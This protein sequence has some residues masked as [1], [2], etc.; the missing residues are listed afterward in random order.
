MDGYHHIILSHKREG[1]VRMVTVQT[2]IRRI[3]RSRGISQCGF[4]PY[5]AVLP[6]LPVRSQSRIPS[7]A[8]TVI[9][10]LFPYYIGEYPHR[11]I[12]RYAVPDDYHLLAGGL[13]ESCAEALGKMFP[14]H[15][16]VPFVDS[17]PIREVQGAYLAGLGYR[18]KNGLLIHPKFGSYV[19]IGELVTTLEI[20]ADREPLGECLSCGR[21]LRACPAGALEDTGLNEQRCRSAITQKKGELSE[22][23]QREIACGGLAWGCDV[24]SDACPMNQGALPSDMAVFYQHATAAVTL[25]NLSELRKRKAF[26]YRGRAVMERNLA[27]LGKNITDKER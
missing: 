16:F 7:G 19:F 25:E 13:L 27:L 18:G 2:K 11:N 10:G 12:S 4:C 1:L 3:F 6:L 22:W 20:P 15:A 9:F 17:S 21:C 5:E 26:N 24:C 23:E 14:G 8:R